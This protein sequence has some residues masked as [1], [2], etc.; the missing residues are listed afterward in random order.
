MYD[1]TRVDPGNCIEPYS[2]ATKIANLKQEEGFRPTAYLD[3]K[4]NL[5]VGYGSNL[6]HGLHDDILKELGYD[7]QAVKDGTQAVTE[8]DAA[9]ML[10]ED[11]EQAVQESE[12]LVNNYDNLDPDAKGVL[13]E[14]VYQMGRTKVGG[15]VKMRAALERADY[16]EAADEML[17]SKWHKNP[18]D[19]GGTPERARRKAREMR[20]AKEDVDD[21]PSEQEVF[22][23][24]KG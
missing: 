12:S 9:K 16:D 21:C 13:A 2:D 11:A 20:A 4:N 1:Y 10:T 24:G 3:A 17:D 6:E 23:G 7:P 15:F 19:K 22:G 5:T 18:P 8:E 14:M